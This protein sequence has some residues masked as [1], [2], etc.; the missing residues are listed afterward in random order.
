MIRHLGIS[1]FKS[2][3]EVY[4][5][6]RGWDYSDLPNLHDARKTIR[7]E[8]VTDL[9]PDSSGKLGGAY[10]YT[11]TLSPR[12]LGVGEERLAYQSENSSPQLLLERKG[13]AVKLLNRKTNSE[14]RFTEVGLPASLMSRLDHK[15]D[16]EKFPELLHFRDWIEKFRSF[17]FWDHKVL[18]LPDR[19][20][21][22]MIGSSGEHLAPY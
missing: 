19:G 11:V 18:R 4:L 14:Q 3:V 13:R 5:Q 2:S 9:A 15:Q 10:F 1:N 12:R 22:E 21:Y 17:L 8:L 7:W 6:D 16:R 20:K